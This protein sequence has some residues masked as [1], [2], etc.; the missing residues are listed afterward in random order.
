MLFVGDVEYQFQ[1][2]LSFL[3]SLHFLHWACKYKMYTNVHTKH[4]LPFWLL[5]G[6]NSCDCWHWSF[7]HFFAEIVL[8]PGFSDVVWHY[9]C[10][11][12]T[13]LLETSGIG[14][15]VQW[16]RAVSHITAST[17]TWYRLLLLVLGSLWAVEH[18]CFACQKVLAASPAR[19]VRNP[20]KATT[21]LCDSQ[22]TLGYM[23][24]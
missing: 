14:L 4:F 19:P 16:L 15:L 13:S 7:V 5:L 9:Y 22:T 18:I 6:H 1:T 12:Q 2:C 20:C 10:V 23:S 11:D 8:N 24:Q 17:G 21:G 3:W